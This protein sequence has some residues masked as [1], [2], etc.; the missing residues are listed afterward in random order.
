MEKISA[1]N[2]KK[3]PIML[4]SFILFIGAFYNVVANANN[5]LTPLPGTQLAYFI[6]YHSYYGGYYRPG[7]VYDGPRHHRRVY[8]TGWRYAAYGCRQHCLINR[9]NGHAIRCEQRC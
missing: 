3:I 6:G 5:N 9:L 8:W 1:K 2:H 4:V 7:Y